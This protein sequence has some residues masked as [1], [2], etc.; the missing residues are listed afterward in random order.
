[1]NFDITGIR[2][3]MKGATKEEL[4]YQAEKYINSLTFPCYVMLMREKDNVY[5]SHAIA[6]YHDCKK[7]GYVS[8]N[9]TMDLL[10]ACDNEQLSTPLE[11][12]VT[13]IAGHVSLTA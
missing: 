5:S 1:M 13:G 10:E 8:E 3:Q 2:F 6:V 11:A 4:T 9:D 7:L 12:Q